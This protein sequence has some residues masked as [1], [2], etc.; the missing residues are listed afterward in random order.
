MHH[1][2]RPYENQLNPA[3]DR[4]DPE[5][6]VTAI[7]LRFPITF[8]GRA[9]KVINHF[10]GSMFLYAYKGKFIV[11][12]EGLELTEY[13]DGTLESPYGAPR[14]TGNSLDELEQWL[15]QIADE[16]GAAD[17]EIPYWEKEE[18]TNRQNNL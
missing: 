1:L 4:N 8:S 7:E 18:P 11:T 9:W 16:Y 15:E 14:W 3:I 6:A 10:D 17:F 12:D 13:G 5:A 2:V